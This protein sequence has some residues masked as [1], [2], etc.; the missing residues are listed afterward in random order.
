MFQALVLW[1]DADPILDSK[2]AAIQIQLFISELVVIV[3]IYR[4]CAKMSS[5][6]KKQQ[7]DKDSCMNRK[8]N[9]VV[10]TEYY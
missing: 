8:S 9:I 6:R 3:N 2:L 5:D 7:N 10:F 1:P 4:Y